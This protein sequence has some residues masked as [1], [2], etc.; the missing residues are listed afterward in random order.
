MIESIMGNIMPVITAVT[1]SATDIKIAAMWIF[2]A[3]YMNDKETNQNNE[4][5]FFHFY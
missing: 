3:I 4:I 5:N 2:L 1:R